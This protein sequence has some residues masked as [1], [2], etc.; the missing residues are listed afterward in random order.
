MRRIQTS[1]KRVLL[2]SVAVGFAG[3]SGAARAQ[4]RDNSRRRIAWPAGPLAVDK[5]KNIQVLKD[6]PA[7]Q[8][9]ATMHFM[10]AATGHRCVDCH[11]QEANGQFSF[12]KDDKRPKNT[13]REMI[14]NV[15]TVND[16]FFKG[17]VNVTCA[18]CH[19]GARPQEQPPLAQLL[20]PEQVAAMA[21][22]AARGAGQGPAA[23]GGGQGGRGRPGRSR[24]R[25]SYCSAR[26]RRP[27]CRRAGWYS[28]SSPAWSHARR[29]ARLG[30][31][32]AKN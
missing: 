25:V 24:G 32:G 6:V 7:D 10:E 11:V 21:A 9:E 13:A 5:Y 4:G 2:L 31:A 8:I 28:S 15:K 12:D 16:E 23:P 26:I 19:K 27:S 18:T 29:A 22:Q 20:T 14:K 1:S 17:S 30:M 3:W